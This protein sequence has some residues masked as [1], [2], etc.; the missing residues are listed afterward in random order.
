[1]EHVPKEE[2]SNW[3]CFFNQTSQVLKAI[4]FAG[5][6]KSFLNFLHFWDERTHP[7][8]RDTWVSRPDSMTHAANTYNLVLWISGLHVSVLH[9]CDAQKSLHPQL[10]RK[11]L[12]LGITT[13]PKRFVSLS[14]DD[15]TTTD[16]GCR[17]NLP[18]VSWA[19]KTFRTIVHATQ[20]LTWFGDRSTGTSSNCVIS[21]RTA[22]YYG[23]KTTKQWY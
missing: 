2:S 23:N 1:M 12:D 3:G 19:G 4:S 20:S 18:N 5:R 17:W 9:S 7:F 15:K 8:A 13:I 6:S 16:I 14:E 21:C 22:T 11:T 10:I